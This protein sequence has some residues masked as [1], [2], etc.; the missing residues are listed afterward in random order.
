MPT[1]WQHHQENKAAVQVTV[2]ALAARAR[3]RRG[4][5]PVQKITTLTAT[6]TTSATDTAAPAATAIICDRG[7]GSG[8]RGCSTATGF[9]HSCSRSSSGSR[10]RSGCTSNRS[11]GEASACCRTWHWRVHHPSHPHRYKWNHQRMQ[12]CGEPNVGAAV[13]V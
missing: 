6:P 9:Q 11:T 8:N 4:S 3:G 13:A 10:T 5:T 2:V 12:R 7:A 1:H